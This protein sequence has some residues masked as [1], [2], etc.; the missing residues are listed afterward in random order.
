MRLASL[1]AALILMAD[2]PAIAAIRKAY[3]ETERNLHAYRHVRHDLDGF[4]TE[5]GYVDAWFDGQSVKKLF[6]MY[7]G[8][9]A[10]GSQEFYFADDSL[11]FMF[12][13]DERYDRPL[14][15]HVVGRDENR[16]YFQTHQLIRWVDSTS[17]QHEL[18][19]HGTVDRADDILTTAQLLM[20]CAKAAPGRVCVAPGQ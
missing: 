17:Q 14:S 20:A 6:A 3:A 4:S 10:R 18:T 8:E 15:G 5:G 11:I 9:M 12:A 1:I 16:F 19:S 7:Y 2:P 13:A